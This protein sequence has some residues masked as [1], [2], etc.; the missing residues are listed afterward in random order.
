MSQLVKPKLACDFAS[1]AELSRGTTNKSRTEPSKKTSQTHP[2]TAE[3]GV[4]IAM[5]DRSRMTIGP[6]IPT[7][8]G[9]STSS[10]RPDSHYLSQARS[11]D[12]RSANRMMVSCILLRTA[13]EAENNRWC[14]LSCIWMTASNGLIYSP[15]CLL[16]ETDNGCTA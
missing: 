10:F 6:R 12:K 8:P 15:V 14:V 9:R 5:H 13:C 7:T 16:P 1:R 11:A 2:K 4:L 3:G